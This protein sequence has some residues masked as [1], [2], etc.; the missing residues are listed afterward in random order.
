M[1][2]LR[3]R[4]PGPACHP[5]NSPAR[6]GGDLW[7]GIPAPSR[8][9]GVSLCEISSHATQG[10]LGRKT[11]CVQILTGG[12]GPSSATKKPDPEGHPMTDDQG[13]P[14]HHHSTDRRVMKRNT[15]IEA[16]H[17]QPPTDLIPL[18]SL[19]AEGLGPVDALARQLAGLVQ[20]DDIGRRAIPRDVARDLLAARAAAEERQRMQRQRR[21]EE[22]AKRRPRPPRGVPAVDGMSAYESMLAAS[23]E[24]E[25]KKDRAGE[26]TGR[27]MRGESF[28]ERF[29]IQEER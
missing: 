20:R 6:R 15:V 7:P 17:V 3:Q 4:G 9:S 21:A 12:S 13:M 8:A 16:E 1:G 25:R 28:G 23:G 14:T 2:L 18:S 10:G 27:L 29:T 5:G 26:R 19:S 11:P 24:D 22:R